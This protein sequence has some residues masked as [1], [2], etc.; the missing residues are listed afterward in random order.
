[1]FYDD[2]IYIRP[3]IYREY[4]FPLQHPTGILKPI[5]WDIYN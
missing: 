2:Y 1:M 4:F 3:D 5:S